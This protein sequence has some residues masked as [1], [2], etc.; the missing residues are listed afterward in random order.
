MIQH[1]EHWMNECKATE[2]NIVLSCH[3]G[4]HRPASC[5]RDSVA[6]TTTRSQA[7]KGPTNRSPSAAAA[8][9]LAVLPALRRPMA[10]SGKPA[11]LAVSGPTHRAVSI[12]T[13][14]FRG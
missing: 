5:R 10:Y 7:T 13:R 14:H 11:I 2:L 4:Q 12:T 8:A 1:D 9:F 6:P 3:K